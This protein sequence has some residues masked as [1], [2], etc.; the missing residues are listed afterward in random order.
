MARR[1]SIYK[2]SELLGCG[3]FDIVRRQRGHLSGGE[4]WIYCGR[5]MRDLPGSQWGNYVGQ[6]LEKD[7]ACD[8]FRDHLRERVREN[9]IEAIRE[10][11]RL[12]GYWLV[13]WCKEDERC[14]CD[15]LVDAAKWAAS[16]VVSES[17]S[18]DQKIAHARIEVEQYRGANYTVEEF[19]T[20]KA[21]LNRL[22]KLRENLVNNNAQEEKGGSP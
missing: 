19:Y 16:Q 15:T 14:H 17:P 10:L 4:S 9:K 7:E 3:T 1:I 13:C 18:L 8:A 2:L 21:E 5:S 6:N 11:R 20:A 12:N 22:I